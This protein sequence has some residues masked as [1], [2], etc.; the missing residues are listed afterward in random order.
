[1]LNFH[2]ELN[3]YIQKILI[4]STLIFI[5]T[6]ITINCF[7]AMKSN[8]ATANTIESSSSNLKPKKSTLIYLP[9]VNDA[10]QKGR[11]HSSERIGCPKVDKSLTALVPERHL[12]L[13]VSESP[14]FWFYIPYPA[15]VLKSATM[16]LWGENGN[17]I[18]QSTFL[19]KNTPGI[20]KVRLPKTTLE[21]GKIYRVDFSVTCHDGNGNTTGSTLPLITSI[22][23][24]SLDT[25]LASELQAATTPRDRYVLYAA[26]SLWYEA[27]TELAELRQERN[28]DEQIAA[29]WESLLSQKEINLPEL[30][31]EPIVDCCTSK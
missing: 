14:T 31:S 24:V 26:N 6:I 25:N 10:P 16:I 19:V 28:E 1:M 29:D 2:F 27:L 13:T 4:R 22:K 17:K 12:A 21:T 20:T 5:Y 11:I 3:K 23:R 15:N 7:F 9:P 18:E 8:P 30:I